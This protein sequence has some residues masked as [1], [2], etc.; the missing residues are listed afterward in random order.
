MS[1]HKNN[2][3]E[4][5]R[6][7]PFDHSGHDSA[8]WARYYKAYAV[9]ADPFDKV[10]A[11]MYRTIAARCDEVAAAYRIA[12]EHVKRRRDGE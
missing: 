5:L 3:E 6:H 1:D 12:Q 4:F 8:T 11:D 7:L 10:L 9:E 2:K